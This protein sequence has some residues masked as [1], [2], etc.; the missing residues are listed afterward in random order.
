MIKGIAG[1]LIVVGALIIGFLAGG[2]LAMYSVMPE[3]PV[4]EKL[5][6]ETKTS[7]GHPPGSLYNP[8][9]GK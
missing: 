1:F 9:V 3:Y 8:L 7:L 5:S 6:D 2:T 4:F